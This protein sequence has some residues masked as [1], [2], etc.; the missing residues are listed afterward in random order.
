MT[1]RSM[2]TKQCT[3]S[4]GAGYIFQRLSKMA[5]HALGI[6]TYTSNPST[7]EQAEARRL[8]VQ[9]R[10]QL[11]SK[12]EVSLNYIRTCLTPYFPPKDG[13]PWAVP[14]EQKG[15]LRNTRALNTERAWDIWKQQEDPVSVDWK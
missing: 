10:H 13:F 11:H 7:G 9:G 15:E 2:T 8:G 6:V 5:S 1:I 4:T 12:S 3:G 14:P